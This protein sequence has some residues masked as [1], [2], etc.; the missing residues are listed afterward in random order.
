[1]PDIDVVDGIGHDPYTQEGRSFFPHALRVANLND[2][3]L[4]LT[5]RIGFDHDLRRLRIIGSHGQSGA[6][7]LGGSH[8]LRNIFDSSTAISM[9]WFMME[10]LADLFSRDGWL[11]LHGCHVA[12]GPAGKMYLGRLAQ[13]LQVPVRAGT[14]LQYG[15]SA[16]AYEFMWGQWREARPTPNGGISF[17]VYTFHPHHAHAR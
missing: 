17:D 10:N 1:M 7:G 13:L 14:T 12:Q 2:L 5:A 4:Q 8:H 3:V 16:A 6:Q 15:G 11:E 9:D